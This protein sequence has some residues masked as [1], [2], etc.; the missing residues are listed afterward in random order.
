MEDGVI[1]GIRCTIR[2]TT[3]SVAKILRKLKYLKFE[4]KIKELNIYLYETLHEYI[5]KNNKKLIKDIEK[6]ITKKT[7]AII[8]VHFAGRPC[9]MDQIMLIAKKFDLKVV[10]DCAH[11]IET[12]YKEKFAG[13][14]GDIG[15]LSFYVT[16]NLA[17]GEGGAL[18][19]NVIKYAD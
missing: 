13:T 12:K 10:E 17:T 5:L 8:P 7:K 19:T 1:S 14:F 15:C 2:S 9:E 3:S 16:K 6:K 18:I 11:A 4:K